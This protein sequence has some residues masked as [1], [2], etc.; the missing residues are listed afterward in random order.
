MNKTTKAKMVADAGKLCCY[1]I[2]LFNMGHPVG[3][4]LLQVNQAFADQANARHNDNKN[5]YKN[6]FGMSLII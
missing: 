5:Y 3:F 4:Y 6:S 1:R 2:G